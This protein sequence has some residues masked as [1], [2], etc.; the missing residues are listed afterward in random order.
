MKIR[1]S[2]GSKT[3]AFEALKA[4]LVLISL[5]VIAGICTRK[6]EGV[7]MY[8]KVGVRVSL[9]PKNEIYRIMGHC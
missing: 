2:V 4:T 1:H 5:K 8:Q 9:P 7:P 6:R 3:T